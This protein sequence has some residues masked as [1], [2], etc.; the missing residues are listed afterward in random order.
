MVIV[1]VYSSEHTRLL[2]H[3]ANAVAKGV[4][5]PYPGLE[6]I[7][8]R[9]GANP[10]LGAD[11]IRAK[12]QPY[13]YDIIGWSFRKLKADCEKLG[14]PL[15]VLFLPNTTDKDNR[16]AEDH[17]ARLWERAVDAGLEPVRLDN[18]YNNHKLSEVQ[19]SGWDTHPN[20]LG[21]RL[22]AQKLYEFLLQ[23]EPRLF[24]H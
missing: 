20:A 22:I 9:A 1:T 11:W 7:I 2:T 13:V 21:H 15:V 6:D 24:G 5:I 14:L 23:R 12:V 18:V 17:L 4:P 10:W 16:D 19:L 8:N 3:I